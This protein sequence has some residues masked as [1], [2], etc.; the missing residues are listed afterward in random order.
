MVEL[1]YDLMQKV[2][3]RLVNFAC[4]RPEGGGHHA[5]LTGHQHWYWVG[6]GNRPNHQPTFSCLLLGCLRNC[7]MNPESQNKENAAS[8]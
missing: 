3:E 4:G 1:R 6:S 7:D 5:P 2:H 8:A